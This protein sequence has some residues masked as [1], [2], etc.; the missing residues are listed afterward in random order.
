MKKTRHLRISVLL[1]IFALVFTTIPA[2]SF[3]GNTTGDEITFHFANSSS[4]TYEYKIAETT[5]NNQYS[6]IIPDWITATT[7][8]TYFSNADSCKMQY[9][10]RKNGVLDTEKNVT[11]Q[12]GEK[13]T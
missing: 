10:Q 9:K 8:Y 6:V 11:C 1:L 13:Y 3:A 4:G 7:V 5:E 12:K 2:I